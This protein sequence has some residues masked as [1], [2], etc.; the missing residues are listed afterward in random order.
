[1]TNVQK[2]IYAARH[3]RAWGRDATLRYVQANGILRLYRLACQIEAMASWHPPGQA[4]P[5]KRI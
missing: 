4:G 5:W 2:A 1:M 3:R